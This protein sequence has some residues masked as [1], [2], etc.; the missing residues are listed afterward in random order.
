MAGRRR[1]Q[2]ATGRCEAGSTDA[3]RHSPSKPA[4]SNPP[5]HL[6]SPSRQE[7]HRGEAPIA[8][9]IGPWSSIPACVPVCLFPRATE[10][11]VLLSLA[12]CAE[13]TARYR[14][15]AASTTAPALGPMA[16]HLSV[17]PSDWRFVGYP[18]NSSNPLYC[19][20]APPRA[21]PQIPGRATTG[22]VGRQQP[23]PRA[24]QWCGC[25]R[26][27]WHAPFLLGVG[28]THC[29][30][31][32]RCGG[33]PS[34]RLAPT[35]V[36]W[37]LQGRRVRH[38]TN[39]LTTCAK[40]RVA[41]PL[42]LSHLLVALSLPL[43]TSCWCCCSSP[44]MDWGSPP[45]T[46]RDDDEGDRF[47]TVSAR[48]F[49]RERSFGTLPSLGNINSESPEFTPL[50]LNPVISEKYVRPRMW[51]CPLLPLV[52]VAFGRQHSSSSSSIVVL[53]CVRH[54]HYHLLQTTV[55]LV[56]E[57]ASATDHHLLGP[58]DSRYL[59]VQVWRGLGMARCI[60]C[61]RSSPR[62]LALLSNQWLT[63][64]LLISLSLPQALLHHDL[65]DSGC[66]SLPNSRSIS[67]T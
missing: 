44:S 27:R 41:H 7:L 21:R 26:A 34:L 65:D 17:W 54:Y 43:C 53:I 55:S 22:P 10:A 32:L 36:P 59:G 20:P 56:S 35:S 67:L 47:L 60:V 11:Q 18:Q 38:R 30:T 61:S 62:A 16:R 29:M 45:T 64:A 39:E 48:A 28:N 25:G 23:L 31:R 1:G 33:H 51:Y 57:G 19:D 4:P 66:V 2:Q 5:G 14:N 50:V 63:L 40:V 15:F 24:H 3:H 46:L 8:G 12:A 6:P 58:A 49:A 42:A 9:G 37:P 13:R 52:A